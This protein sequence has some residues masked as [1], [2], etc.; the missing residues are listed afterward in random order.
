MDVACSTAS[1]LNL[2]VISLDRYMAI[3]HPVA[4]AQYGTHSYRAFMSILMVWIISVVV[5]LPVFFGANHID[6][7]SQVSYT[8]I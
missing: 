5:A 7:S 1:I 3:T 2:F 6:A 8:I 4:Y